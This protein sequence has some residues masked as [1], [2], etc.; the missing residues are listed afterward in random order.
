MFALQA[1]EVE[2]GIEDERGAAKWGEA[3]ACAFFCP[4]QTLDGSKLEPEHNS[5]L[6]KADACLRFSRSSI[7]RC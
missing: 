1:C 5:A 7:L 4:P 6:A 2:V 3:Q